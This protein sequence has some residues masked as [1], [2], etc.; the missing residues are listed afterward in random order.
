MKEDSVIKQ[1]NMKIYFLLRNTSMGPTRFVTINNHN[2]VSTRET[3]EGRWRNK[4]TEHENLFVTKKHI[5]VT[6]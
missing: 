1:L 5:N 4:T 2:S 3:Y 6:N